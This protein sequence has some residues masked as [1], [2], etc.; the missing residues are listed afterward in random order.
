MNKRSH[1]FEQARSEVLALAAV[2]YG[3]QF[4]NW[5]DFY[6]WLLDNHRDDILDWESQRIDT[7][8]TL[9]YQDD[10]AGSTPALDVSALKRN[11]ERVFTLF[12]VDANPIRDSA[13]EVPRGGEWQLRVAHQMHDPDSPLNQG[14]EDWEK[15]DMAP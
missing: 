14:R 9:M 15:Y 3:R 11:A 12:G 5:G 7:W 8:N 10:Q 6:A 1:Y 4:E 13:Y 2:R